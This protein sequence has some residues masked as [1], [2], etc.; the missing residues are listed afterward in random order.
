MASKYLVEEQEE[1]EEEEQ[2]EKEEEF[3]E[4]EDFRTRWELGYLKTQLKAR[5][6]EVALLKKQLRLCEIELNRKKT[7]LVTAEMDVT[8]LKNT[9]GDMGGE[10]DIL[11]KK[12]QTNKAR[13]KAYCEKVIAS[14]LK[15]ASAS[16]E[17]DGEIAWL[18]NRV[19]AVEDKYRRLKRVKKEAESNKLVGN[20]S[21]LVVGASSSSGTSIRVG[22]TD[23]GESVCGRCLKKL[24]EFKDSVAFGDH[25]DKCQD[26]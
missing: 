10:I 18:K 14:R 2:E 17:T 19:K 20:F 9:Q 11:R 26:G 8:R 24:S 4:G 15:S 5:E 16:V 22:V 12:I 21:Q 23:T 13:E 3:F 7:Q 6:K 1:E 25:L